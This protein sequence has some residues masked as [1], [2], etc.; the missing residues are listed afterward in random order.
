M[1]T[2]QPQIGRNKELVSAGGC[3][4]LRAR[5]MEPRH[6]PGNACKDCDNHLADLP[7]L[8]FSSRVKP[9]PRPGPRTE[10]SVRARRVEHDLIVLPELLDKPAGLLITTPSRSVPKDLVD[11]AIAIDRR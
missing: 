2:R 7:H 10:R 5:C 6:D 4:I 11:R 3:G 1:H 9:A 8:G